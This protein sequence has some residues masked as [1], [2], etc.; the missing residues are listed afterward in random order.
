MSQPQPPENIPDVKTIMLLEQNKMNN[1]DPNGTFSINQPHPIIINEGDEVALNHAFV[2][3]SLQ[4]LNFIE[5]DDDE[6]DVTIKTG[7]YYTDLQ[8]NVGDLKPSWG[9]WSVP[10]ADRPMAASF[11][12]EEG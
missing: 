1:G 12:V 9:K 2:D 3:T 5:V 11:A 6:Q 4:N 8:A 7:I 10:A